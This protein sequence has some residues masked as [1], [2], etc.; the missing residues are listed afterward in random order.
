MKKKY[1]RPT[2]N[3]FTLMQHN[4]ILAGSDPYNVNDYITGESET[5]GDL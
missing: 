1:Q 3:I 5:L 4:S 2:C